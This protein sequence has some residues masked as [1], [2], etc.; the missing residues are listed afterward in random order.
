MISKYESVMKIDR[1]HNM[2]DETPYFVHEVEDDNT[3]RSM[4]EQS[5]VIHE[6]D[7]ISNQFC[8]ILHMDGEQLSYVTVPLSGTLS[9][10]ALVDTIVCGNAMAQ[11]F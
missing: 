8:P 5:F 11:S 6:E 9:K 3:P 7:T 2:Q 4:I 10:R 1:D